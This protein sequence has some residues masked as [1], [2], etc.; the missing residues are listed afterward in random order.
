MAYLLIFLSAVCLAV[1]FCTNKGYQA[2]C[3]SSMKTSFEFLAQKG[4]Y[5][6]VVFFIL[7]FIIYKRPLKITP[8]SLILA[9]LVS[10]FICLCW[11]LGFI[12][13]KHGPM[14]AYSTF[15]MIGGMV[16][17]FLFGAIF[18]NDNVSIFRII[19]VILL[20]ISLL[21]PLVSSKGKENKKADIVFIILSLVVFIGNGFV[22]ILSSIHSSN[23]AFS[24]FCEN[25]ISNIL[26]NISLERVEPVEFTVLMYMS[27]T[28][29]SAVGW[30]ILSLI[31]KHKNK[32]MPSTLHEENTEKVKAKVK[33]ADSKACL[34]LLVVG[35]ATSSAVSYIIMRVVDGMANVNISAN[36]PIQTGGTVL[37]TALA[38]YIVFKE[39]P[40]KASLI[41][42]SLTFLATL[43]FL[44]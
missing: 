42:L 11:S 13:Y 32:N 20:I 43:L 38:G 16:L 19:G 33:F 27:N 41:G 36:Y 10:I 14:S 35:C 17:P 9:A 12:I 1:Q 22:S 44:F 8:M 3:G 34:A 26:P 18:L 31:E 23:G 30:F 25:I 29:I 37:L 6:T 5:A 15:M 39:K 40:S 24:W 4:I 28:V 21:F 7:A 2:K